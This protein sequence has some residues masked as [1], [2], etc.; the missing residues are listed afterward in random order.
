MFK[1]TDPNHSLSGTGEQDIGYS[2]KEF[3]IILSLSLGWVSG[4][5]MSDVMGSSI[6]TCLGPS[7]LVC[8]WEGVDYNI[9]FKIAV[10]SQ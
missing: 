5:G 3:A 7:F 2:E 9:A 8:K 10:V 1:V 4:G 6:L